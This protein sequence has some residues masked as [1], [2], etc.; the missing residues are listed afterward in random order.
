MKYHLF[1]ILTTLMAIATG[2]KADVEINETNFPDPNF[3]NYLLGRENWNGQGDGVF[4]ETEIEEMWEI[5]VEGKGVKNLKG[6]EFFPNIWRLYC[7]NNQLTSLDLSNNPNLYDFNCANNQLTSLDLSKNPALVELKCGGNRLNAL[8]VSKNTKLK[9][10]SCSYNQLHSLDLSNNVELLELYINNN[11]IKGAQMEALIASLPFYNRNN[12]TRAGYYNHYITVKSTDYDENV[13]TKKHVQSILARGW[14]AYSLNG[15]ELEPYEGINP[16]GDLNGDGEV[17][18]ADVQR[19][20]AIMASSSVGGGGY[21]PEADLNGD[22]LLNS[23][24]IQRLYA[25]MAG[26]W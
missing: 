11:Y 18:S 12:Q 16:P 24:D 10:I 4:S 25:I 15:Y 3:R 6:I 23:A 21:D 19:L 1:L 13:C 22:G 20:Y 2:A 17:N 26:R 14:E 9:L 8:D 7:Y 5:R